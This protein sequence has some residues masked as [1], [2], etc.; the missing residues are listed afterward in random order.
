MRGT[1]QTMIEIRAAMADDAAAIAEL[2]TE[3]Y[4]TLDG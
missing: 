2:W 1:S 3:A 4:V